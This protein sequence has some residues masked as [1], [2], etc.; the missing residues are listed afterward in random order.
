MSRTGQTF[1]DIRD[2]TIVVLADRPELVMTDARL[3]TEG[4][5]PLHVHREHSD[6]FAILAGELD[7]G[8]GGG[9]LWSA[10]P[11]VAHGYRHDGTGEVRFLNLHTPGMGFADYLFG[12]RT[13]EQ[14]DQF[15]PPDDG[16]R[17]AAHATLLRFAEEGETIG[18][19][20]DRTLRI[21]V[22]TP[23]LTLTWTR[24][25]EGLAGPDLHVHR[26]HV[27]CF[28]VLSGRLAFVIGPDRGRVDAG[29]GTFVLA[30]P[31][32]VHTF[33]NEGPGEATWFN[34]HAPAM[35]FADF[36]RDPSRSWDSFDPPADGGLP[37]SEATVLP[38]NGS[39]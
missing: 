31:G 17:P 37:A 6:T 29:P 23:E 7:V 4:G 12:R 38:G 24:Y 13:P 8:L 35:G 9:T 20:P 32:V 14:A 30:P 28:Y 11:G 22:D 5:P 21:L 33:N 2:A 19:A 25:A 10:P 15:E 3:R 16:G 39:S 18:D 36:L 26:E 27:D 34:I 1:V